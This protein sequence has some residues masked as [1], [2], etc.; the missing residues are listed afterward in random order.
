[1]N[2]RKLA[3]IML[4]VLGATVPALADTVQIYGTGVGANGALLPAGSVDPH[5]T[6]TSSADPSFP[7]PAAMVTDSNGFPF[8][9]WMP[10][11]PN[12]QWIAPRPDVGNGNAPGNYVYTTTFDLTGFDL[13]TVVLTG[14]WST[15]NSGLSI[16]INGVELPFTTPEQAFF[17]WYGFTISCGFVAGVNTLQFVVN[18][19]G[20]PNCSVNPTG[21]RVEISGTGE[22]LANNAPLQA[23]PEP[24]T[25]LLVGSGL[26]GL[27]IRRRSQ[28]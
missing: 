14:Q 6:I 19:A 3:M 8:P 16:V 26:A 24:A 12:S 9:I 7:G 25:V 22:L 10:N 11:G 1:M 28:M 18:N 15:D 23:V 4:C 21:L 27:W 20:C 17:G 13:S 2:G 5:Y